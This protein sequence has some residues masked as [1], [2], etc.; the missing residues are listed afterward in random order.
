LSGLGDAIS[1][2]VRTSGVAARDVRAI[3]VAGQVDGIVAVDGTD[4]PLA[5]APIWMDRRATAELAA[6]VDAVGADA[7]RAVSGANPDASHGA[8]K[9]AWLRGRLPERPDGYLTPTGFIVAAFT[10]RRTIDPTNASSL[11]LLDV[12]AG[13]WSG[14]LLNAV[15]VDPDALGE[16]LPSTGVAGELNPDLAA[17]WGLAPATPVV[18][19][20]GDEHA[21]CLAA[22]I[23]EPGVLGDILGT[24]EPVAA[25]AATPVRDPDGLVETHAHVR[26]GRWLIEHPGFVSA[27]SVR[28]LAELFGCSQAEVLRLALDA[29]P[30]AAGV[31]FV[32]ALGGASTPRWNATMGGAFTGLAIGHERR[33]VARAVLEGCAFAV[34]DIVDRLTALGLGGDTIRVVGGGARDRTWLQIKADVTGHRL[35]LLCE[36]EATA[37]GAALMASVG[38][39]WFPDLDAASA[40]T[41]KLE[42]ESIEPNPATAAVYAQARAE[43]R[44]IFDAL[45][46]LSGSAS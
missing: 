11:L 27:G 20:S 18:V 44:A 1:E 30:G 29:P 21:A 41:L 23:L 25:V 43:S 9:I 16:L 13:T 46:P 19:G 28:W 24:A 34:A 42:S 36:P 7:I 12:E 35:E 33:Q 15:G 8:P 45:E 39:G 5:P 3:G 22:G 32:P 2:L 26:A 40:A 17:A 37:L 6:A 10:G 31:R 4:R 14:A 38:A